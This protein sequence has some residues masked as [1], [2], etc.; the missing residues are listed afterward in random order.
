MSGSFHAAYFGAPRP[1]QA[2]RNEMSHHYDQPLDVKVENGELVI[3]IGIH[4]L[5]HAVSYA[6]WA[7]PFDTGC[8]DNIRTFAITDPEQLARDVLLE[9]QSEAEDGSSPLSDFLDAMT[10]AALD[11]GSAAVEYEQCIKHGENS[12][13]ETWALP[14]PHKEPTPVDKEKP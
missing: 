11:G 3:H 14:D 12:P 6:D 1:P 13:L 5:A 10:K 9:M 2:N 8:D 4:T 7:A